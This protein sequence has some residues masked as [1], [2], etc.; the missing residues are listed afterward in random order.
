MA[1]TIGKLAQIIRD[2]Y[3][4]GIPNDDRSFD[5]RYWA[6]L[7]AMG[8]AEMATADAYLNSNQGETTFSND[9]F[10]STY[11][12]V[13]IQVGSDGEKY[14]ILPATP[15]ALPNNQ[16]IDS[17]RIE[18]NK[19]MDIVPMKSHASFAQDLIPCPLPFITYKIQNGRLVYRADNPLFEGT[20]KITMIGAINGSDLM[21]TP[22]N[23]PKNYEN[24][25]MDK[26]LATLTPYRQI[27]QDNKNDS[28]SNPA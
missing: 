21:N 2:T 24:K 5:D 15:A 10:I 20:V 1:T 22:L 17:V 14:S 9:N 6:E 12:G 4:R 8:V 19:C 13:A 11:T 23:I 3:Y 26:I 28:I 25:I 7:V 18:G 27:A 16:E